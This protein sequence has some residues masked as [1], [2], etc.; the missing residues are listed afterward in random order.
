MA[1]W[2][3]EQVRELNA[4][5]EEVRGQVAS[6]AAQADGRLQGEV[7]VL[8]E[9]IAA[10][11]GA[12]QS[13]LQSTVSE[14]EKQLNALILNFQQGF[15]TEHVTREVRENQIIARL[16]QAAQDI[17]EEFQK[18]RAAFGLGSEPSAEKRCDVLSC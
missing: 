18:H 11:A 2:T 15:L 7:A 8:R 1:S 12:A 16:E 17:R 5:R 14:G 4:L 13:Q 9:E 10:A 3:P 6:S